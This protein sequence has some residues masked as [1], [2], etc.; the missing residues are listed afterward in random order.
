VNQKSESR[1]PT[2]LNFLK[3]LPVLKVSKIC[4]VQISGENNKC[5]ERDI[6]ASSE[7]HLWAPIASLLRREHRVFVHFAVSGS[8]YWSAFRYG[9]W[10]SKHKPL[11]D[12]DQEFILVNGTTQHPLPKDAAKRPVWGRRKPKRCSREQ[13][14]GPSSAAAEAEEDKEAGVESEE[15]HKQRREP[16]WAYA[17]R[18]IRDLKL[19][20]EDA[21]L[22]HVMKT[23]DPRLTSLCMQ[24]S[25]KTLVEKALH[26]L[27]ADSRLE[28]SK[29]S[30]LDI[31]R[32]F[33]ADSLCSCEHPAAWKIAALELLRLQKIN[34]V[35][36][37]SA[38]IT[39]LETGASKG[40]NI[41]LHGTTTSGKSWILDPLR[42]IY[43]CHFTPPRNSGFPLQ[44]LPDKEV[45]LWQ[46]FRVDEGVL[47]WNGLLLLFEGTEITIRRPRNE[48][49]Q[50]DLDYKVCQPAFITSSGR[51]SH[52]D[53]FDHEMMNRRFRFFKFGETLPVKR[54]RKLEPCA[55][56]FAS[57]FLSLATAPQ[58]ASG[59]TN[60]K[61][62]DMEAS[63][64]CSSKG[65]FCSSSDLP[66]TA[67]TSSASSSSSS[68]CSAP[69]SLPFCG[70]CGLA[71]SS[72]TYCGATGLP[73]S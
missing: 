11:S 3:L 10:P 67:S 59:I 8:G 49:P 24:R 43:H 34:A 15:P 60:G 2:R 22:A 31:L 55:A 29:K 71:L 46:D 28:R 58:D 65:P 7:E 66:R 64:G 53:P 14:G 25:A 27:E 5:T 37:A 9:W 21:F 36:F 57:L 18:L 1:L 41:F 17:F 50:G 26:L 12:V 47:S 62:P 13:E 6:S 38:V 54:V 51:P 69:R 70:N 45:I 52:F 72:S 32:D 61:A 19:A 40:V 33:A 56:C 63:Q 39:A 16:V 48:F 23:S 68:G 4:F 42:V 30:R 44:H 73:H 20:S 35:E